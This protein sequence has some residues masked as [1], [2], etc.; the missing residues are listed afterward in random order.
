[1]IAFDFAH[2]TKPYRMKRCSYQLLHMALIAEDLGEE[3]VCIVNKEHLEQHLFMKRA[4]RLWTPRTSS[5][6]PMIPNDIEIYVA[7]A[8]AFYRDPN[9]EEIS[10]LPGFRVCLCNS[11]RCFRES[12]QPFRKHRGNPV[13]DRA[14]LYM[15]VNHTDK[16]METHSH[17]II[18]ISH[19]I[20][21]RMYELFMREGVY[22]YY[23]R[24]ELDRLQALFHEE[25]T[26][27]AGFMGNRAPHW[28]RDKAIDQFPEWA[29]FRWAR[30]ASSREFISW[31]MQYRGCIDM[32]GNGDKSLRFTEA[33]MLGRTLI[34][35]RRP[36]KYYPLLED[37]VNCLLVDKWAD[38]DGIYDQAVWE[39]LAEQS[40]MDYKAGWSLRAQV[41]L[42]IA[43]AR[44]DHEQ[45]STN[46]R[47]YGANRILPS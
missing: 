15:P 24:D 8:D 27:I 45:S 43:R 40:S 37:G 23:L 38:L 42:L 11:D 21:P 22:Y 1:M 14:D 7:K 2:L 47:D 36:S 5:G 39:R 29:E 12:S 13:Q 41:K 34:C 35:Q 30:S 28:T 26:K 31:M 10:K 44:G 20:D 16:I 6:N 17:K 25:E 3:V 9:W 33:A 18:P 46:N 32:R 4:R 19:P